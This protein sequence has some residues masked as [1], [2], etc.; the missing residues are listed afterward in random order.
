MTQSVVARTTLKF[1]FLFVCLVFSLRAYEFYIYCHYVVVCVFSYSSSIF[2]I[3]FTPLKDY[4]LVQNIAKQKEQSP[5]S[6]A[7]LFYFSV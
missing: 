6:K 7:I 5:L 2:P 1:L 4:F 3:L